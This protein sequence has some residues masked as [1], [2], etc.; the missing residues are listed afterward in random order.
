MTS[1]GFFRKRSSGRGPAAAAAA[2]VLAACGAA[3]GPEVSFSADVQPIITQHCVACHT[4]GGLGYRKSGRRLDSYDEIMRGSGAR[5]IVE[6]GSAGSSTLILYVH[7]SADPN[8]RMPFGGSTEL[9]KPQVEL[10][11]RWVDQGAK[12][13]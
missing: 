11:S 3:D 1:G 13:N 5:G 9:T 4:P 8:M 12:N 2:A 7:P 6:P 10:L